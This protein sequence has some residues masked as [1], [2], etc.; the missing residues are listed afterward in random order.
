MAATAPA[1]VGTTRRRSAELLPDP[2]HVGLADS[3]VVLRGG[4]LAEPVII[5]GCIVADG[6]KFM[7]LLK[8][9]VRLSNFLT[10]LRA[11]ERPLSR[12]L[13]IE[14]IQKLRNDFILAAG[15]PAAGEEEDYAEEMEADGAPAEQRARR[16]RAAS[17]RALP[18]YAEIIVQ[19]PGHEELPRA[20]T[21][22]ARPDI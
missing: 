3:E 6:R 18:Q 12:T 22:L 7:P 2:V 21:Q 11:N 10:P 16:R 5:G 17:E 8:G 19:K 4:Y 9:D 15:M 13:V 1:P 20:Q 14:T